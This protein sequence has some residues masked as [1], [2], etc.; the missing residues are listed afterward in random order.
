MLWL[1]WVACDGGLTYYEK[2]DAF[3]PVIDPPVSSPETE[4]TPTSTTTA[5]TT[6]TPTTTTPT[7][8]T[9]TTPTDTG[10]APWSNGDPTEPPPYEAP[11][12]SSIGEDCAAA[13]GLE[14]LLD[15]DEVDVLSH[16]GTLEIRT[17]TSPLSGWY[18]L[19]DRSMA[20]SG[21]GE[22][23]ESAMVRI[24]NDG[25]PTG[26][27]ALANCGANQV[28][29]D[30]DNTADPGDELLSLGTFY[31]E[32]GENTLELE[33]LCPTVRSGTCPELEFLDDDDTTCAADDG[34]SAHL[35]GERLCMVP[36]AP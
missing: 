25:N 7:T 28:T 2:P 32:L 12:P 1:G 6:T 36:P 18:D 35:D 20:H 23:N 5:P 9:T 33:H 19:Y 14:A 13:G 30:P 3:E 29:L 31:F 16:E 17:L 15:D 22:W 34:N 21:T 24:L 26:L 4:T 27:P 10:T 11:P 8:P